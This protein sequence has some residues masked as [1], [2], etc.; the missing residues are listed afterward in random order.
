MV[1]NLEE[2]PDSYAINFL[3][4]SPPH[5]ITPN[6]YDAFTLTCT[7][8]TVK[9]DAVYIG[10]YKDGKSVEIG[11]RIKTDDVAQS[12]QLTRFLIFTY[13][14]D[15]DPGLYQCLAYNSQE[16]VQAST[17]VTLA[18]PQNEDLPVGELWEPNSPYE[19][20]V[21]STKK[22]IEDAHTACEDWKPNAKLA[23]ILDSKQNDEVF[24]MLQE[25]QIEKAWIGRCTFTKLEIRPSRAGKGGVTSFPK[26]YP[27]CLND[28]SK[29]GKWVWLTQEESTRYANWKENEPDNGGGGNDESD[30]AVMDVASAGRWEDAISS[31]TTLPFICKYYNATCPTVEQDEDY[32]DLS[33]SGYQRS[34][35]GV[36]IHV[37][38]T[39]EVI[40]NSGQTIKVET[41]ICNTAGKWQFTR[42]TECQPQEV[43]AGSHPLT[44]SSLVLLLA[45]T[46]LIDTKLG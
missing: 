5:T 3:D 45:A 42:A 38:D 15:S 2:V 39:A 20:K 4:I 41:L 32:K 13:P 27:S 18:T 7:V 1:L 12:T 11:G 19:L 10:W 6:R 30:Y 34:M 40:C 43:K 9:S 28:E 25:N 44:S 46:F 36:D 21:F 26:I 23:S 16:F 22:G 8:N 31:D 29:E 33:I 37:F 14:T 17:D 35:Q 24:R